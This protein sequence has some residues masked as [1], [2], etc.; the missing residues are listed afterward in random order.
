MLF[1]SKTGIESEDCRLEI[2]KPPHCG[3]NLQSEIINLKSRRKLSRYR[4]IQVHGLVQLFLFDGFGVRMG[5]VNRSRPDQQR[6]SP[7]TECWD[8]GGESGDHSGK[9]I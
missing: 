4:A 1:G 9:A 3:S 5:N 8:V 6:L 7:I 2:E